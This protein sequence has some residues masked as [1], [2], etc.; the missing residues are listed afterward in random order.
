MPR[1]VGFEPTRTVEEALAAAEAIHGRDCSIAMHRHCYGMTRCPMD[2]A[3]LAAK[4][5][6]NADG[7]QAS[8]G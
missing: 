5:R 1:H 4:K 8:T 2:P 3:E 6:F 7:G